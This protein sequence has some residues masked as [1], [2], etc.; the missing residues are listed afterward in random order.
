MYLLI[1][2]DIYNALYC[3]TVGYT[4]LYVRMT[5]SPKRYGLTPGQ[6]CSDALLV[7]HRTNLI[8]TAARLLHQHLL[9][10]YDSV[11]GSFEASSLYLNFLF[12]FPKFVNE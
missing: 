12:F 5:N 1:S 2:I 6:L 10:I 4:F 11:T 7:Q 3:K 8:R 9:T